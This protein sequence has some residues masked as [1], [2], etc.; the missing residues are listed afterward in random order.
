MRT[1]RHWKRSYQCDHRSV[2]LRGALGDALRCGNL[3]T[4]NLH[5]I[6]ASLESQ[7]YIT[8]VIPGQSA[9]IFRIAQGHH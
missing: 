2:T 4:A 9:A 3:P 8:Y 5:V 7:G 6:T 1:V